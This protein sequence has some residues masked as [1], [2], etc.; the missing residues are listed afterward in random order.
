MLTAQVRQRVMALCPKVSPEELSA[1][2]GM[3]GGLVHSG[4]IVETARGREEQLIE[5]LERIV[6]ACLYHVLA[7]P[8][9]VEIFSDE[10]KIRQNFPVEVKETK[11]QETGRRILV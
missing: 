7:D 5:K 1:I 2:I 4:A 11:R 10:E 8:E 6:R 9:S 3:R